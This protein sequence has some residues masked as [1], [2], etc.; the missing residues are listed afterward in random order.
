MTLF[1]IINVNSKIGSTC[2]MSHLI[3]KPDLEA[4]VDFEIIVKNCFGMHFAKYQNDNN[5]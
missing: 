3:A 1:R 4:F 2:N 5:L